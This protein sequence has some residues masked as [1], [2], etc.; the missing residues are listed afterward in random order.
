M[1]T[2]N[3]LHMFSSD[4]ASWSVRTN[5]FDNHNQSMY[6][7]KFGDATLCHGMAHWAVRYSRELCFYLI[8][9]YHN[10]ISL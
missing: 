7:G 6:Y 2:A 4:K 8:N 9:S 1:M 5:F 10:I 3:S